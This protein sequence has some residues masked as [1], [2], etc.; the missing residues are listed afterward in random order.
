MRLLLT[1]IP[2]SGKSYFASWLGAHGWGM[3]IGDRIPISSQGVR[4]AWNQLLQGNDLLLEAQMSQFKPGYVIEWGFPAH[5]LPAV[6]LL[7]AQGFDAWFFDGDREA[8]RAAWLSAWSRTDDSDWRSQ[9][10]GLDSIDREITRVFF[11]RRIQAIGP[12]GAYL[13]PQRIA[14]LLGI[15]TDRS[16]PGE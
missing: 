2:G 13:K 6:E 7:I 4:L 16:D 5:A 14:Q 3:L 8:A 9:V 11:G 10:A 12:S 15:A 1:G